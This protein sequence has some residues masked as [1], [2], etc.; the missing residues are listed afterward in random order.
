M[1]TQVNQY[2]IYGVKLTWDEYEKLEQKVSEDEMWSYANDS[3]Y[4]SEAV[5]KN[6][7][8]ALIDGMNGDYAVIGRVIDKS[9]D[10]EYIANTPYSI[11]ELLTTI[12]TKDV[13]NAL[14]ECFGI[15]DECKVY[16]CTHWS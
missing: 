6:G 8:F 16:L 11:E 10:G 13:K 3:C 5:H 15:K 9:S 4:S 12:D 2:L 1:S 7:L 14:V